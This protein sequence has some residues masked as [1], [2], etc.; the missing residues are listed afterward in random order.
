[1]IE[2]IRGNG[3][4][5]QIDKTICFDLRYLRFLMGAVPAS[6][7]GGYA[8]TGGWLRASVSLWLIDRQLSIN[9]SRP[10]RVTTK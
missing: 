1:M 5:M 6:P 9:S 10:L 2:A 7:P 8:G 4:A 3:D